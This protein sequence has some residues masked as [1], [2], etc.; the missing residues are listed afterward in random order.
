MAELLSGMPVLPL[1]KSCQ[2]KFE[3]IDPSTGAAVSGVL[4]SDAVI[5]ATD[6][7][8]DEVTVGDSGPFMLVPGSTPATAPSASVRP[9]GGL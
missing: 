7:A 6:S 5:Y 1:T 3:A 4:I 8:P 9:T 2:V